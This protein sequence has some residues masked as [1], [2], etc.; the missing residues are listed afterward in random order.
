MNAGLPSACMVSGK[1][2]GAQVQYPHCHNLC[3]LR[4]DVCGSSDSVAG[5]E[6]TSTEADLQ[7][8]PYDEACEVWINGACCCHA[9][10]L[11]VYMNADQCWAVSAQ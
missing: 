2:S 4:L 10:H 1:A 6:V 5:A 9:H 11:F 8:D 7:Q 3:W